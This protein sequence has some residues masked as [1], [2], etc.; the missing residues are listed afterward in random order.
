MT[1]HSIDRIMGSFEDFIVHKSIAK[2]PILKL[3]IDQCF[4]LEL[5]CY[6]V[7]RNERFVI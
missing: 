5:S 6:D 1:S 2:M 4:S 7:S 3:L